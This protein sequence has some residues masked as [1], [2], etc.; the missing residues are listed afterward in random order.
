MMGEK[1]S[2]IVQGSRFVVVGL[3]QMAI[4]FAVF[5][6]GLKLGLDIGYA[7]AAGR[8]S[9][10]I[11]GYLINGSWTFRSG[12]A[13]MIGGMSLGRYLLAWVILTLVGTWAINA[14]SLLGMNPLGAKIVIEAM[15]AI[16]SFA[17]M[18]AWVYAGLR[19]SG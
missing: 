13:R 3:V 6:A 4:D 19:T 15:L 1:S 18:R 8:I 10:A 14:L 17:V 7:N 16:A 2:L 11:S 9:G 5:A 12:S